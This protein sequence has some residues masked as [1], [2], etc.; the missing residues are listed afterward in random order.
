[1][2][3]FKR[4][5]K[6]EFKR[7]FTTW[8]IVL[9]IGLL[10]VCLGFAGYGVSEYHN[11]MREKQQFKSFEDA[12]ISQYINYTQYGGYGI[13]IL[14]V[15]HPT[16]VLFINTGGAPEIVAYM[17][18]GERLKI[19]NSLKGSNLF[20]L[21]IK[22][23]G[24]TDFSGALLF[25][26]GLMVLFYGLETLRRREYLKQFAS[27]YSPGQLFVALNA[28]RILLIVLITLVIFGAALLLTM[29]FGVPIPLSG[30]LF[31]Y[32]ASCLGALVFF[33]ALGL[34]FGALKSTAAGVA[35]A[36]GLWIL[37]AYIV[38]TAADLYISARANDIA[39]LHQM[40]MDKLKVIMGFEKRA[41]EKNTT[42]K[43]G[44][45]LT[46]KVKALVKSYS[47]NEFET[48]NRMEDEMR[49]GMLDNIRHYQLLSMF[50]PTTFYQSTAE[51]MGSRG[52]LNIAEFQKYSQDEKRE[53]FKFYM[54]KLY[55]SGE[56][57]FAKIE[58]YVKKEE[59]I[60]Y[61]QSRLPSYYGL[62]FLLTL[63]YT[64]VLFAVS[65]SGYKKHLY[66]LPRRWE[67]GAENPRLDLSKGIEVFHVIDNKFSYQMYAML[68]GANRPFQVEGF[69]GKV[70]LDGQDL[71]E[72]P[73]DRKF[74]YLPPI[75]CMPPDITAGD[76]LS[77][78]LQG[79]D[80]PGP[81]YAS[82]T[83]ENLE[84][85]HIEDIYITILT[86]ID[87]EIY[88]IDDIGKNMDHRF[89]FR[90]KSLMEE[91]AES[92]ALILFLTSDYSPPVKDM[93]K[94]GTFYKHDDWL[95]LV[96]NLE[97]LNK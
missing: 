50:F 19:Y 62:G 80:I 91:K 93:T 41:I 67:K 61:A 71:S 59:N 1:M 29:V 73:C 28:A 36:I 70:H 65:Y 38:P 94:G 77:M 53:F 3:L 48:I 40:E 33:Y 58:N 20:K 89:V 92:G 15:P 81:E 18:S 31:T 10:A 17:D 76:F 56:S 24:I 75:H 49:E 7:L 2:T 34:L 16:S 60:F 63:L 45:K 27:L 90:L 79:K 85:N 82:V 72:H 42:Y 66:R 13:R 57:N 68:S 30:D 14:F 21:R 5:G 35:A 22:K 54:D 88:L 55:F 47:T 84:E 23:S 39:S 51:E 44:E 52:L 97:R 64:A 86:N 46:D 6:I 4:I 83:I 96:S 25:L 37:L 26:G 32:L 78:A 12:K 8:R 87:K 9:L 43:Y 95:K 69:R 74:F 11:L